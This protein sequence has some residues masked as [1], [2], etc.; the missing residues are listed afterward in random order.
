MLL[1]QDAS[2]KKLRGGYYTPKILADFIINIFK[3]D[4]DIKNILEPSCGDGV[5][6]ESISENLNFNII[7]K[8]K[9]VEFFEE[10]VLKAK[11]KVG[12]NKKFNIMT[13]DF[14]FEYYNL[15]KEKPFNLIVGNPPY[16][17]YQY[18]TE[19]Q[20]ELQS[21]ILVSHGMKSNKLI[22]SWVCFLVA[23]IQ[24]LNANGKIAFVLPAEILQVAYAEDLRLF[25][26]NNLSKITLITFE[27]LIFKEAEQEVIIFIGEKG[28]KN[29]KSVI[30]IKQLKNL[31][32]LS[33]FD[34]N[35]IRY[36]SIVHSKDKWTKYFTNDIEV[37][38]IEQIRRDN[39]FTTFNDISIVNV[40]ITTGN[41]NYFSVN[42]DIVN[43]YNLSNVTLPLIGR[44]SHAHGIY[45]TKEDW[46]YNVNEDKKAFLINFPSDIRYDDYPE[47]HKKYIK[48]GEEEKINKGY[49]CSIRDRW[50]IVPSVWI[51]DA[52]ILRRNDTFP[53]FV[54]NNINAV[55]T[56]TM[57]RIK[58]NEGINQDKVLLA[59]YNSITF[60]FTEIS[61]RS[62]GGGVLEI[63]P[64]EV[65]KVIIPNLENYNDNL[66][67]R[68][69]ELIDSN[70]RNNGDIEDVLNIIDKNILV[71]FLK[72]DAQICKQFR[73]IWKKLMS[74][75]RRRG[76]KFK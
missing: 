60:A 27:D 65:G 16:I 11:N 25:L 28:E 39:R 4:T 29:N 13:S 68:Y 75:R 38:L 7:D 49:K 62:Y 36:Q 6:L 26:S 21:K 48:K 61:G 58:F 1:K 37:E 33:S 64:G 12:H 8:V 14:M 43:K 22:N 72:I 30:G 2:I 52:F 42:K 32:C 44:S 69:L 34:I 40:G 45:F 70:I 35:S 55:S 51:P 54:L 66:T 31:K 15:L 10:E 24:L 5:F 47:L 63:L 20:R 41:N 57:H 74:R 76:R 17:R 46:Q 9:A 3:N 23:C 50:Y 59:Y 56:D 53:K 67:H 71:D 18:L 73:E 19:S